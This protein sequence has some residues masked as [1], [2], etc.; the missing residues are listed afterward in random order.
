MHRR[1]IVTGLA[2][3][4]VGG[5]AT[6]AMAATSV[7]VG[8]AFVEAAVDVCLEASL[9]GGGIAN[10]PPAVR[11]RLTV[12]SPGMRGL[13]RSPNPNGEIWEIA[14]ALGYMVITEPSPGECEVFTYGAPVERTFKATM[15]AALKKVPALIP[16]PVTP[17]YDPI[18]YRLE[19]QEGPA[20][21]TLDL[22]GAEPG[23]PGHR[24]R[25]PTLTARTTRKPGIQ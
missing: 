10:L 23:A 22:H 17:G 6:K 13:V 3:A 9:S 5:V 8:A 21:V 18:V 11:A 7:D 1:L 19:T 24:F 16:V 12:A 2:L 15:A 14:S 25:F 20:G 4:L